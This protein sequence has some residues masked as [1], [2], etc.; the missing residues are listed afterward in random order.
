MSRLF[1]SRRN[2]PWIVILLVLLL[3]QT[4]KIIV[5]TQMTL[6]QN[7]PV[8]GN[9]FNI[10]FIEN[11]G[12][13]FGMQF[14]GEYGKLI[15]SIFRIIAV[16]FIGWYIHKLILQKAHHGL[17]VSVSLIMAGAM[18]NIIDSAFYG[19]IFSESYF[20]QTAELMPETGGYA[21]FLHGRVVDMLY[22]PII[23]GNFPDWFP[24]RGGQEFIFFRPVFNLADSAITIGVL[25]LLVFQKKFFDSVKKPESL[26]E[27]A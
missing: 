12:M 13:A 20:S 11:E 9:W 21:T 5:K 2:L 22:F 14:S 10:Y 3:D 24:F 25:I 17:I 16:I 18:G 27:A 15:L 6:G 23:R 19:L 8:L 7:I 26:N 4:S 1:L